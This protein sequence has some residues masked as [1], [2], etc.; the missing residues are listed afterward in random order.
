MKTLYLLRHAKAEPG[1]KDVSDPE[2]ILSARGREACI[3]V[4]TYMKAKKYVPGVVLCSPSARTKETLERVVL[5]A[6]IQPEHRFEN[7][8]YLATAE[9]ILR[10]IHA[11][12]DDVSSAMVVGHNPGMHH[13]SLLLSRPKH[14]ELR[15]T[16][17]LKFPTCAFAV[18][19]F[20]HE[21]WEDVVPGEGML[22]DFVTPGEL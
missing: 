21:R 9:E 17:E 1:G 19:R 8:L 20:D 10:A 18:L 11:L 14:T 16:L 3:T 7:T 6:G 15:T 12:N 22:L 2:R 5:A 13:I 4:G